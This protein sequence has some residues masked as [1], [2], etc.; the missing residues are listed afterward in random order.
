[1]R[2]YQ[3]VSC[4]V[5]LL[6][7]LQEKPNLMMDENG[8]YIATIVVSREKEAHLTYRVFIYGESALRIRQYGFVGLSLWIEG[9]FQNNGEIIAEKIL[10]LD[11]S[12]SGG[13]NEAVVNY[14]C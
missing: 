10:F 4:R 2:S 5:Y 8:N 14:Y 9:D 6:G 7:C 12:K 3:D 1:M 11:L 13:E